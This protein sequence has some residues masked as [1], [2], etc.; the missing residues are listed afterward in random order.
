[1][2]SLGVLIERHLGGFNLFNDIYHRTQNDP[3]VVFVRWYIPLSHYNHHYTRLFRYNLLS[4]CLI[5]SIFSSSNL[6]QYVELWFYQLTHF[7]SDDCENK[8]SLSSYHYQ[9]GCIIDHPLFRVISWNSGMRCILTLVRW[10][11]CDLCLKILK[12]YKWHTSLVPP[13]RDQSLKQNITH[14]NY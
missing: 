7:F 13:N 5:R 1:M 8:C 10:L 14:V 3:K 11:Q 4:V 12:I 2:V 6:M 9:I